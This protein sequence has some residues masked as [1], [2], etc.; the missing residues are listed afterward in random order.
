MNALFYVGAAANA[1]CVA[2]ALQAQNWLLVAIHGVCIL[3]CLS[4]IKEK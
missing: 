3:F 1:F 4:A 2:V